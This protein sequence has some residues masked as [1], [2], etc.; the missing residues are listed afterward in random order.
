MGFFS[1]LLFF[2]VL[3]AQYSRDLEETSQAKGWS[4]LVKCDEKIEPWVW[5]LAT[6]A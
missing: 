4:L 1:L 3:L 2:R 5:R 6:L